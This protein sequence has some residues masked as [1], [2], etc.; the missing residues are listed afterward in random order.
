[1][2]VLDR[3]VLFS[4]RFCASICLWWPSGLRTVINIRWLSVWGLACAI[5]SQRTNP[6]IT[7]RSQALLCVDSSAAFQ[8]H[9]PSSYHGP[10][11]PC[12]YI[13]FARCLR[14]LLFSGT[15]LLKRY[16]LLPSA[17]AYVSTALQ[18]HALKL[19]TSLPPSFAGVYSANN[20][21]RPRCVRRSDCGAR[22]CSYEARTL[23]AHSFLYILS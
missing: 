19:I 23:L 8:F 2:Q 7:N 22:S 13:S 18:F 4:S 14:L 16:I 17:A 10:L 9:V 21:A 3:R 20:R 5:Y 15:R 12:Y 6:I 11:I 1:M